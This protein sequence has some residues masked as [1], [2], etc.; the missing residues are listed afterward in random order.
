MTV[1]QEI[2]LVTDRQKDL[3]LTVFFILYSTL[4]NGSMNICQ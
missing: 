2:I 1:N 4:L 3:I